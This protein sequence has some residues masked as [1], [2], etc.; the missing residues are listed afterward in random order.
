[1]LTIFKGKS[2]ITIKIG[3]EDV[4]IKTTQAQTG[5]I[6]VNVLADIEPEYGI[7]GHSEVREREGVTDQAVNE[8]IGLLLGSGITP[9]V[10]VGETAEIR[11]DG[12]ER[13]EEVIR[14]QIRLVLDGLTPEQVSGLRLA[15]EPIW[16]IGDGAIRA[17]EPPEAEAGTFW[18][19]DEIKNKYGEE[20]AE[21]VIIL[22]GGSMKPGNAAE[23]LAQQD[24]DGGL[25]GG[26]SLKAP[27]M[28]KIISFA[29]EII[30][31]KKTMGKSE[32]PDGRD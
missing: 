10:C 22:Y 24:I 32:G 5:S 7:T 6:P 18:I 29:Q 9:I 26:S 4:T 30:N 1:M 15:Y 19:R 11:S 14:E 27:D 8:Q 12:D 23:L 25:I 13:A 16:A 17:A 31:E 3:A 28:I 2:G 20:V 21:Q